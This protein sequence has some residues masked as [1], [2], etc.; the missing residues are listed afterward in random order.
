MVILTELPLAEKMKTNSIKFSVDPIHSGLR[1]AVLGSFF[2]A[3]IVSLATGLML[4]PNGAFL[5]VLLSGATAAGASVGTERYLKNKWPSGR[6][7][8]A[9]SERI[10]LA[11][12]GKIEAVVDVTKQV[13]IL[14]WRFEV[15]KDGPRA[16]KGWHLLGLG[17][18]QDDNT[19]VI[20]SAA[21]Q[22]DFKKMPLSGAFTRLEKAK[23]IEKSNLSS[24]SG[25]RRAGEQ[26]R[27]FQAEIVRQ[28]IG[29]DM[30]FEQFVETIE[31]LQAKYPQWMI[32]D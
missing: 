5:A 30:L 12:R 13:N 4:I 10:A 26:K 14:A 11:K 32:T 25:I 2:G 29:G 27:L 31:F 6:E 16:K 7:F 1:M 23:N 22:E 24:S 9:D 8:L 18:E 19:V 28:M 17:L 21:S 3:G 20:Y 15:K